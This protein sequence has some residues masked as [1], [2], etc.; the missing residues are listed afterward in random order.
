MRTVVL[1]AGPPGAGKTTAARASGLPVYDRD[2]ER[3]ASDREFTA[4]LELLGRTP[5]ARAVVIRSGATSEARAKAAAL[6]S[7]T[8]TFV[9]TAPADV[10]RHRVRGRGRDDRVRTLAGIDTWLARFDRRDGVRDFPGWDV[11]LQPDLG[12]AVY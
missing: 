1:L 12:A 8:A 11:A 10:L 4:A 5:H 3:W 9:L 6:V 7:A 2:D